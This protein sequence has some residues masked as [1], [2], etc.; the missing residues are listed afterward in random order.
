VQRP[1]LLLDAAR[2]LAV[3]GGDAGKRMER[4][5]EMLDQRL[6][7]RRLASDDALLRGVDDQ[8]VRAGMLGQRGVDRR[9]RC[10]HDAELP[11]HILA[12]R[13]LPRPGRGVAGSREL[14]G[15][16]RALVDAP[17]HV[18]AIAPGT[19]GEQPGGLAEGVAEHGL[20]L[21]AQRANRVGGERAQA[22]LREDQ[23][24]RVD[25]HLGPVRVPGQ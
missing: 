24:T 13:Q 1:V 4:N 7:G 14:G 19:Q 12:L 22:D 2:D 23:P 20:R 21:D 3:H 11:L 9:L 16:Q 15:E 25:V 18:V 8:P 6:H 10:L 17:K 5:A